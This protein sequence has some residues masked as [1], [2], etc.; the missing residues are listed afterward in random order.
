MENKAFE[1]FIASEYLYKITEV[2]QDLVNDEVV[3]REQASDK[4]LG[5]AAQ[6]ADDIS[7]VC[8]SKEA[9]V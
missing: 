5:I 7:N 6:M 1:A 9:V 8:E 2:A 3:T 4:L